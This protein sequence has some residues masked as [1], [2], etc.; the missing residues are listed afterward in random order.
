MNYYSKYSDI[1]SMN[2]LSLVTMLS[3]QIT[4]EKRKEI[5]KQ[6]TEMNNQLLLG[7][8]TKGQGFQEEPPR[9]GRLNSRKKDLSENMH[10]S[11]DQYSYKGQ[12]PLPFGIPI[13]S[14]VNNN[15]DYRTNFSQIDSEIDKLQS[16]DNMRDRIDE[17]NIDEIN[18]DE[19][20]ND[21]HGESNNDSLDKKLSK[22][23]IL[24]DKIIIDKRKKRNELYNKRN[25]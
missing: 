12:N 15:F 25:K 11:F 10:P 24:Q 7:C 9:I 20:I 1:G 14:S 8:G 13:N 3:E 4:P 17:I 2:Y 21:I 19:I 16:Q 6:L 23:K 5:L 22:I 18:I